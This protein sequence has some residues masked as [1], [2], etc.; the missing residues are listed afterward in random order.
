MRREGIMTPSPWI[1]FRIY[2]RMYFLFVRLHC[3]HRRLMR[4]VIS[5]KKRFLLTC[6]FIIILFE[7]SHTLWESENWMYDDDFDRFFFFFN[8]RYNIARNRHDNNNWSRLRFLIFISSTSLH[9]RFW[10]LN[11]YLFHILI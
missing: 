10:E 5:E 9:D 4:A 6:L 3:Q 7:R 11:K 8:Q 2:Y 1:Y